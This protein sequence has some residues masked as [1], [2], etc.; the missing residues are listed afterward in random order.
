M[1]IDVYIPT[2]FRRATNNKDRVSVAARTTPTR[3]IRIGGENRGG[4]Q[5][6][7]RQDREAPSH[8][9]DECQHAA[10]RFSSYLAICQSIP[11]DIPRAVEDGTFV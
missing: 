8:Q 7:D 10:P 2:P 1:S 11:N 3:P 4:D 9:G 5:Q 6:I